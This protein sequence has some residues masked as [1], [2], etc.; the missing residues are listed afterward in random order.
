M[1]RFFFASVGGLLMAVVFTI[2]PG[3]QGANCQDMD[4]MSD[5]YYRAGSCNDLPWT[6]HAGC[7]CRVVQCSAGPDCTPPNETITQCVGG[8]VGIC[9]QPED[10]CGGVAQG[11]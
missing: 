2:T 11:C 5:H 9:F 1:H 8:T 10:A 6:C 4:V 7:W 3:L